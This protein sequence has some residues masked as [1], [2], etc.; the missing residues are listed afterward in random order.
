M[1]NIL[2]AAVAAVGWGLGTSVQ[3]QIFYE[4]AQAQYVCPKNGRAFYYGGSDARAMAYAA[5]AQ[6]A[7]SQTNWTNGTRSA[8]NA[9]QRI[10]VSPTQ[11]IYSD[12]APYHD[13]NEYGWT[14]ADA[15][16]QA[17]ARIAL[18]YRRSDSPP[19]GAPGVWVVPC[20]GRPAQQVEA[21]HPP[22]ANSADTGPH[23]I[24]LILPAHPAAP[25]APA[26]QV[27]CAK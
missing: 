8:G 26:R 24:I 16:N 14:S 27:A 25:P 1:R 17:N 6:G 5:H 4:P 10:C 12:C 19:A 2:L 11:A 23:G 18:Y 7:Y 3:A 13:M 9:V 20:D 22:A 21:P 15:I